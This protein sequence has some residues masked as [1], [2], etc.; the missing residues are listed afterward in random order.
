VSVPWAFKHLDIPATADASEIR[1]AYARLLKG[2]DVDADVDGYTRLRNARDVALAHAS[3]IVTQPIYDDFGDDDE[4]AT[5]LDFHPDPI[6]A[7]IAVEPLNDGDEAAHPPL[8]ATD[9]V[10]AAQQRL[11]AILFPGGEQM[12]HLTPEET[13]EARR[14]FDVLKT[15]QRL[16]QLDIHASAGDWFAQ[17]VG[18]S[19]PRSDP[20][21][22][23]VA[24]YFGWSR[25]EQVGVHPAI[26]ALIDRA[27][28]LDWRDRLNQKSHRLHRAWVELT[29]PANE[30][31]GRGWVTRKRITELLK[32]VRPR[33]PSLEGDM[34]WYR[35]N[36]WE[37]SGHAGF[38]MSG[39][40]LIFV[41][42]FIIQIARFVASDTPATNSPTTPV[43]TVFT[44]S[45]M[46]PQS[47]ITE[48]LKDVTGGTV[49]AARLEAENPK[50]YKLVRADWDDLR[51]DQNGSYTFL[52]SERT[53]LADLVE[54]GWSRAPYAA[55]RH[56]VEA[57]L[58]ISAKLPAAD[59]AKYLVGQ[60]T[61]DRLGEA[62][63]KE[64][65]AVDAE[66]LLAAD[67]AQATGPPPPETYR[68]RIPG[69]VIEAAI[70]KSGLTEEKFRAGIK[71][72]SPPGIE[73]YVQCDAR[74][75]L[76]EAILAQPKASALAIMRDMQS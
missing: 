19:I 3:G 21:V 50:L 53:F 62:L 4:S 49:D 8:Q 22:R 71:Y 55:L 74:R 70:A 31:S 32:E 66:I 33:Y 57:D 51:P 61:A 38:E 76:R 17:V 20:L 41:V 58:S 14:C 12:Y 46:D 9:E 37:T 63:L 34:D 23:P 43:E 35:V 67:P 60:L 30:N 65:H 40:L 11:I 13:A 25:G 75:A 39:R 68:Y 56:K 54:R 64:R 6:P 42:I 16:E 36:L 2:M 28:A 45:A 59:C 44:P 10:S 15:D 29:T 24:D 7:P 26:A 73:P 48:A 18:K 52:R 69:P 47:A 1:R 72:E 27:N 5:D